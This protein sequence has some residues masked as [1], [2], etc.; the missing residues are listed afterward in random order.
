MAS[1][2]GPRIGGR[3]S[4]G[5]YFGSKAA[6]YVAP[7]LL[8]ILAEPVALLLHATLGGSP[9][10]VAV[11]SILFTGMVAGTWKTWKN[12][13]RDTQIAATVFVGGMLGWIL[14]AA[15]TSPLNSNVVKA[16]IVGGVALAAFWNIRHVAINPSSDADKRKADGSGDLLGGKV[17]VLKNTKSAKVTDKP[18]EV[19]ADVELEAPAT[20]EELVHAR[21]QIASAAGVSV[22]QVRVLKSGTHEG[23]GSII[24][25]AATDTGKSIRYTGP[26]APGQSIA[27][28]ALHLGGRTDGSDIGHWVVGDPTLENPR[29]V[30]HTKVT[31]VSGS[32]KTET[33]KTEILDGRWRIDF[34]PIVGDPAKFMQSFGE[35]EECLGLSA[36]DLESCKQLVENFK[37]LIV[38]RA[39]L[40]GTLEREDGGIGYAEWVPELWTKHRIPF[41]YVDL[42][43]AA[44]FAFDMGEEL[45]EALRKLRSVGVHLSVSMQTMPHTNISRT[46]RGAFSQSLAHGQNEWQDCKYSLSEETLE[47]GANPAKWKN[48]YPGSLYAECIGTDRNLWPVDGRAIR[49]SPAEKQASIQQSRQFWA[50]MDPGS[51]AIL[52]RGIV[53]QEG[54]DEVAAGGEDMDIDL[55][56]INIHEPL[57]RPTGPAFKFSDENAK[58][59]KM[60]PED[61]FRYL[62]ERID[63]IEESGQTTL[64]FA[65]VVDIPDKTGMSR[66]WVYDQLKVLEERGRLKDINPPDPKRNY[67]IIPRQQPVV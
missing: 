25:S 44:D 63:R 64:K 53:D 15:T 55:D 29:P 61:A 4:P 7:W 8:V 42:E 38:Y 62:E 51:Y 36:K 2:G 20:S 23:Q 9:A 12:R 18:G 34:V 26:S 39:Q 54:S 1:Q 11:V 50:A 24:F 48:D 22:N 43:E 5:T 40:F 6:P 19:R 65:D 14:A 37:P 60:R 3:I 66:P 17:A 21:G 59:V 31:G 30:A 28:A 16:W 41:L 58:P 49:L 46:T 13:R 10:W 27:A 45:D 56:G 47:A 52:S 33:V 32:G 57:R 67:Y 35:I